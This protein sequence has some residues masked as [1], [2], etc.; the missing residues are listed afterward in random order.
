TDRRCFTSGITVQYH[1]PRHCLQASVTVRP[2]ALP[3]VPVRE[4][5]MPQAIIFNPTPPVGQRRCPLCGV[6]IFL[7]QIEPTDQHAYAHPTFECSQCAYAETVI[8]QFR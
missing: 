8:V 3:P 5:A 4:C 2:I 7:S 1:R 6:P